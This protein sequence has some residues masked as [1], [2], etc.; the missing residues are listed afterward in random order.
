M[1]F[2]SIQGKFPNYVTAQSST[3]G[4]FLLLQALFK[5]IQGS[6]FSSLAYSY[7]YHFVQY[8]TQ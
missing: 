2:S 7:S 6:Y 3:L 8:N 1:H 4:P 5:I